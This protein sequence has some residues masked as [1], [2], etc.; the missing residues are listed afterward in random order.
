MI[1]GGF[2]TRQSNNGR[3][4]CVF[5]IRLLLIFLCPLD[6]FVVV[7]F[8]VDVVGRWD[9]QQARTQRAKMRIS[10]SVAV[11]ASMLRCTRRK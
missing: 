3:A 6:R 4:C 7:D 2:M 8:V 11:P 9:R 1:V 10:L 5:S